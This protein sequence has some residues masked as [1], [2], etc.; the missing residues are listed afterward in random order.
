MSSSRWKGINTWENLESHS[1]MLEV[2][3]ASTSTAQQQLE[4]EVQELM[5]GHYDRALQRYEVGEGDSDL[6]NSEEETKQLEALSTEDR[7]KY[8]EYKEIHINQLVSYGR[9]M[10]ISQEIRRHMFN[11][12]PGIP[13]S[14]AKRASEAV[15]K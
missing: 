8:E 15:K 4:P 12:M 6:Y 3:M 14:Y 10:E 7:E 13:Q 2:T 9:T 11:W 1:L 5:K